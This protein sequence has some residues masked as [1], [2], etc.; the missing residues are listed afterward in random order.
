[1][2]DETGNHDVDTH[3]SAVCVLCD[4]G[5]GAA[6]TLEDERQ[7]VAGNEDE[8]VGPGLD[9]RGAFP[10]HDHDAG[11]AEIYRGCQESGAEG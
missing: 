7:E 9:S 2:E 5:E 11:E 6:S 8:G 10:I 4:G 1:M 3:L